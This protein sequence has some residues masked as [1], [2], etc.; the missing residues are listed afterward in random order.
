MIKNLYSEESNEEQSNESDSPRDLL[1]AKLRKKRNLL[2]TYRSIKLGD[3]IQSL[4][5]CFISCCC[6]KKSSRCRR[7]I[8]NSIKFQIAQKRYMKEYDLY[9]MIKMNRMNK[10]LHK[11]NF[12]TRQKN[13]VS[14]SSR[15]IVTKQDI[16]DKM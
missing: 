8:D 15:Y 3:Y 13:M 7:H 4:C 9:Y 16:A 1:E 2:L 14:Y 10:L 12:L 5:C 6:S 11:A